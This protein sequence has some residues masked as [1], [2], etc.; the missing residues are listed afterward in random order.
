MGLL[1]GSPVGE[2]SK[3]LHK[4]TQAPADLSRLDDDRAQAG[5]TNLPMFAV[6]FSRSVARHTYTCVVRHDHPTESIDTRRAPDT[7]SVKAKMR[8][9]STKD[10]F[11]V[12][13]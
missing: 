5:A 4:A 13:C 8:H 3:S 9:A 10:F 6:G 12:G 7:A 11:K 2:R 1:S